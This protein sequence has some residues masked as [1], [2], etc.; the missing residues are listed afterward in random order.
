MDAES[1]AEPRKIDRRTLRESRPLW[2]RLWAKVDQSAGLFGCWL[3]TGG[4]VLGRSRNRYGKIQHPG[5]RRAPWVLVHRQVLEWYVGPAPTRLHQGAHVCHLIE[6]SA[7]EAP[8]TLCCNP[9]HLVWALH[10]ENEEHKGMTR[11][12]WRARTAVT[13]TEVAS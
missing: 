8:N 11:E 5:G 2:D 6:G 9:A 7:A 4:T 1:T 13:H 10:A 3:W 12:E